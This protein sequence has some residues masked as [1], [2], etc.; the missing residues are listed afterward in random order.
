[1]RGLRAL[2]GRAPVIHFGRFAEALAEIW[3][4]VMEMGALSG[5]ERL[6]AE[7]EAIAEPFATEPDGE[8]EAM[9]TRDDILARA[10]QAAEGPHTSY[11][12]GKGGRNPTAPHPGALCDC[13]GFLAWACGFDRH[14][15]R[16]A[17]YAQHGGWVSTR[18][19]EAD[20]RTGGPGAFT[21][22]DEAEAAPGDVIVY[23][24]RVVAGKKKIGHCGIVSRVAS[25]KVT[26][27]IHCSSGNGKGGK[28]AI[29]ETPL[30]SF[31]RTR[32]AIFAR[33]VDEDPGLEPEV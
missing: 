17:F 20:A 3:E 13:S 15:P 9:I 21:Q 10:R 22:V 33:L 2:V 18:S 27:V 29:A 24:T 23:G 26:H 1:V 4:R 19:I 14:Q 5:L 28:S 32:G 8:A 16:S 30:A 31:W 25:G 7:H 6:D 11:K 12:L